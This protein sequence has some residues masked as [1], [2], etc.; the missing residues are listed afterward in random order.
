[1]QMHTVSLYH[2]LIFVR[3]ISQLASH[4]FTAKNNFGGERVDRK[5]AAK[6]GIVSPPPLPDQLVEAP[7]LVVLPL[8]P[9]FAPATLCLSGR[10]G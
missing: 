2:V 3:L 5:S 8:L 1:M 9:S 6:M 7:P 10:A 4:P